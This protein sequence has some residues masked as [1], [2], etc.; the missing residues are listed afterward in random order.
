MNKQMKDL[1]DFLKKERLCVLGTVSEDGIPQVAVMH[2]S[3][4]EN[5]LT[6]FFSTERTSR[7]YK[8]SLKNNKA[9][10]VVGWSEKEWIT[11]QMDGTFKELT[12]QDLEDAKKIHYSKHPDSKQYEHD[13]NTVFLV[14]TPIWIRI[15][16][17]KT[18][19]ATVKVMTL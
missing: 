5:P 15:S 2:Y 6:F 10:C 8:N 4:K 16:D 12:G 17:Y 11:A 7:K 14:F 18:E 3:H 19:P 1:V 9:S 13:P